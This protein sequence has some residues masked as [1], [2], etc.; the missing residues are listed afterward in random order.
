M[1]YEFKVT[2]PAVT[3]EAPN[4]GPDVTTSERVVVQGELNGEAEGWNS[5]PSC[6][7]EKLVAYLAPLI[8]RAYNDGARDGYKKGLDNAFTTARRA[9]ERAGIKVEYTTGTN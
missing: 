9:C 7:S 3:V 1:G 4:Q 6:T 2:V 5:E 8:E